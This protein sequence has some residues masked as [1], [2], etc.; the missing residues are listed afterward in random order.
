VDDKGLG[1]LLHSGQITKMI[2]SFLGANKHFEGLYL[3]G[4]VSLELTPQVMD[5]ES[6]SL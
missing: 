5:F 3:N 1:K 6:L 4:K 2:A